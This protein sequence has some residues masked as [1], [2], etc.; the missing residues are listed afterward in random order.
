LC[1]QISATTNHPSTGR[2]SFSKGSIGIAIAIAMSFLTRRCYSAS[3]Q[4]T[5]AQVAA[6]FLASHSSTPVVRTQLLDANQYTLLAATLGR[7]APIFPAAHS[8]SQPHSPKHALPPTYHLA[9][10]TPAQPTEQLGLDGTDTSYNPPAPFTRR[11]WAGGELTWDRE[12]LL[13]VGEEV[14]ETT[15][16]KTA[17]PKAMKAGKEMLVVG[18]EKEFRNKAGVAVVDKRYFVPSLLSQKLSPFILGDYL[19]DYPSFV[20]FQFTII[21]LRSLKPHF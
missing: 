17:V 15:T 5:A 8:D 11:M 16:V 10:F 12:N 7:P 13:R 1:Y 3:T 19:H 2:S 9:Y 4:S 6:Q 18:V 21:P 20:P 14:T